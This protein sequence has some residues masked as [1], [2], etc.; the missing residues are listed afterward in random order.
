MS[1]EQRSD[2][3]GA[4]RDGIVTQNTQRF[5]CMVKQ[6][7]NNNIKIIKYDICSFTGKN[8]IVRFYS[9]FPEIREQQ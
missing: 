9:R 3:G 2:G 7:F 5:S 8:V 4:R 6:H 1:V